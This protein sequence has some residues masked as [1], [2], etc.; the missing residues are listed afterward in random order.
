MLEL[1]PAL[2]AIKGLAIPSV[3]IS[4]FL[5]VIVADLELV[6]NIIS[7]DNYFSYVVRLVMLAVE[8]WLF[9]YFYDLELKIFRQEKFNTQMKDINNQLP[10]NITALGVSKYDL[11]SYIPAFKSSNRVRIE[12]IEDVNKEKWYRFTGH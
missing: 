9:K 3:S 4:I 2:K 12:E 8:I 1:R 10:I 5:L 7:G 11:D 6:W